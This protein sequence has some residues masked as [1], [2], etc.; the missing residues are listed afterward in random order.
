MILDQ[1]PDLDGTLYFWEHWG[2]NSHV[3]ANYQGGYATYNL[4]GGLPNPSIGT[5]HPDVNQGGVPTKTPGRYVPVGQGFF[6]VGINDG[7]SIR[8]NNSQR[9]FEKES[10]GQSVFV[11]APGSAAQT[12]AYNLINTP[13]D[14]R[15]KIRLGFD[16]PN[17][18]HRQLLVT[19]DPNASTGFDRGYDAKLYDDQMDDMS[20]KIGAQD[21]VIQGIDQITSTTALPLKIKLSR[22]G[23][24][25]VKIDDLHHVD[26]TQE[27][28]LKDDLLN[29]Y[30]NLMQEDYVSP[31]MSVGTYS[32]R[33]SIVFESPVTLGNDSQ[34]ISENHIVVFTP[35][36]SNAI[37]IK[38][39]SDLVIEQVSL[40]NMLGQ[41]VHTWD[42]SQQSDTIVVDVAGIA[43][44]N[45]ILKMSDTSDGIHTRKL[46]LP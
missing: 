21:Y 11:S 13:H 2:G 39:N 14:P 9:N 12:A 34:V 8:F 38:N 43:A 1:N 23:T 36:Q 5:S 19:V 27:I 18:I 28:Y 33:F 25:V 31:Q 3:Y 24:F 29:T 15:M 44:G 17:V 7:G 46:I 22:A 10:G 30:T 26:P 45:Y 16:S 6:V 42:T 40:F 20:W 32:D 4:S 35:A 37:H 41:V